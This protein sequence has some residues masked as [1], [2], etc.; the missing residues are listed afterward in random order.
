MYF[1]N[2]IQLIKKVVYIVMFSFILTYFVFGFL[3]NSINVSNLMFLFFA[4]Q[5]DQAILV[6]YKSS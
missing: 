3:D 5:N 2:L 4:P 6:Y 1:K